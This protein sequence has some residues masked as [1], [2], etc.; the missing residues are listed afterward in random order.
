[1]TWTSDGSAVGTW[2]SDGSHVGSFSG[3]T[4]ATICWGQL[5]TVTETDNKV[6]FQLEASEQYSLLVCTDRALVAYTSSISEP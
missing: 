5:S 1:M 6:N 3:S 2:T 4:S